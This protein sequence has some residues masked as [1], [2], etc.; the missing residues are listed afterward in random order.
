MKRQ[1][2]LVFLT[3]ALAACD[4]MP[5]ASPLRAPEGQGAPEHHI[6]IGTYNIFTTQTPE[7]TLEG[8]SPWEVGTRFY[9]IEKGCVIG[10]RFWRAAG[11]TGTNTLKLWTSS[12]AQLGSGSVSSGSGWVY[13]YF[14][15]FACLNPYE[16]YVVSVN[17]NFRQVKTPLAFANGVI[18][19]GPLVADAGFYGQPAGSKPGT[20]STS[21]FF[22]DVLFDNGFGF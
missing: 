22:V 3:L 9:A 20:Q 19:N 1:N 4:A 12:G 14:S 21:N 2:L 16:Y 7:V 13:V 11:E 18:A 6:P 10:L 8:T 17:T 15:G 5:T